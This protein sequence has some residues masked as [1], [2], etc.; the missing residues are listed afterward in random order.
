L[1]QT[2]IIRTW[3]SDTAR[4][5][6]SLFGCDIDPLTLDE[7]VH[8]V[9]RLI[10]A[11]E[12]VQ[13][14]VINAAK[15]VM[16]QDDG[17]L[18]EIV[19][20]CRLVNADGQ[21]VVWASRLLGKPLPERVTGID[22]FHALLRLAAG[23]GYSVYFLGGRPETVAEAGRRADAQNPGLKVVGFHHGY[24]RDEDSEAVLTEVQLARPQILFVGMPS[25]R[26]EYWLAE[27]LERLDV[28]FA[29]G[30]GG[31]FDV[32][33]GRLARAPVWMQRIGLEWA[34]RMCQEPRKLWKRYLVG[35][36]R[37]AALV[38]REM[39]EQRRSAR[40]QSDSSNSSN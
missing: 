13:H 29:M 37:F 7:T 12:P 35:N 39:L 4:R 3:R 18:R 20:R 30:V 38:L 31:S 32:L 28:P 21:S 10:Q 24:F 2:V 40:S 22:L 27:N 14:C 17:R 36:T 11:G 34:V 26:K 25:P 23:K 16:L 8:E 6:V 33:A 5:R 1:T 15:A 9:E 19:A